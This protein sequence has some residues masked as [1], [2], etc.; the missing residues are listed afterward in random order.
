MGMKI[1]LVSFEE[2]KNKKLLADYKSLSDE[3]NVTEFLNKLLKPNYITDL[4]VFEEEEEIIYQEIEFSSINSI[5][6]ELDKEGKI[7]F[8]RIKETSGNNKRNEFL[9][10]LEDIFCLNILLKKFCQKLLNN[11]NKI[12]LIII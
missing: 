10:N 11:K 7:I 4:K 5:S 2:D 3:I 12:K 9:D 8:D 1:V 6:I